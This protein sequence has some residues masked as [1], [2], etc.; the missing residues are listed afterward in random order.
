MQNKNLKQ[1]DWINVSNPLIKQGNSY[2]VRLPKKT[3]DDLNAIEGELLVLRVKKAA[4]E[5]R[6][7]PDVLEEYV[8]WARKCPPLRDLSEEKIKVLG[9]LNHL[10]TKEFLRCK[11]DSKKAMKLMGDFRNKLKKEFGEKI[12]KQYDFFVTEIAKKAK[13]L[14]NMGGS[15]AF[16]K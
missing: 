13:A 15:P 10:E 11:G 3:I 6:L 2:C 1:E 12:M 16:V 9:T 7:T 8:K 14:G 5:F 4:S